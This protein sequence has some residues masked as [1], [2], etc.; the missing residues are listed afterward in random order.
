MIT[1]EHLL[2]QISRVRAYNN[3]NWM[4]ILKIAMK[5][6]PKSTKDVLG[7]ILIMD[8]E[9]SRLMRA[10]ATEDHVPRDLEDANRKP[11]D[12]S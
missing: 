10:M 1:D 7:K 6:D 8:L 2:D 12:K 11:K 9:V 3:E 5:A 4:A